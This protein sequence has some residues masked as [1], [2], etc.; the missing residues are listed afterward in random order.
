MKAH[1][2]MQYSGPY[3]SERAGERR[4]GRE[5]GRGRGG[6]GGEKEG[7]GKEGRG[8][9]GGKE[10]G[11]KRKGGRREGG[12]EKVGRYTKQNSR[13]R[14]LL[15]DTAGRVSGE[16]RDTPSAQGRA[17]CSETDKQYFLAVVVPLSSSLSLLLS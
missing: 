9:G 10:G 6:K 2:S 5:G 8:K 12:R 15:S 7:G 17:P 13:E 11:G 1:Q 4:G 16:E 3:I 14:D